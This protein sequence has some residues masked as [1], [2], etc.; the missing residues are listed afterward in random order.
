MRGTEFIF[1]S[2]QMIQYKCHSIDFRRGGSYFDTPDW[3]KKK[4]AT[5]NPKNKDDKCLEYVV[6]VA[7]N[8]EEIKWNQEQVSNIKSFVNKCK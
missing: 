2:V 1:D 3:I 8:Y 6:T 4:K 7:L 5:I